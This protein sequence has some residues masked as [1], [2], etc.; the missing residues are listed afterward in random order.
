M[1]KTINLRTILPDPG[2]IT[3]TRDQMTLLMLE[4]HKKSINAAEEIMALKEISKLHRLYETKPF[5]QINN[6]NI[7]NN[8]KKLSL[9]SDEQLLQLAGHQRDMF[10]LPA[11]RSDKEEEIEAEFTEV[12][13]DESD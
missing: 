6:V 11:G 10:E 3:V 4:S 8:E 13:N 1:S 9:L 12:T 2:E 5:I 7:A